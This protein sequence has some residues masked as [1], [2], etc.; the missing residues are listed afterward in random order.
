MT[1]ELAGRIIIDEQILGGK[2]IIKGTRIPLYLILELLASG[3]NEQ[4]VMSEYP[5]LK[6]EDIKAS[7]EYASRILRNEEVIPL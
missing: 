3:M 2:P 7:L 6:H 1:D 5:N 4:Q